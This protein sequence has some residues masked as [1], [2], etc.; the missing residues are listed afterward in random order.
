MMLSKHQYRFP[1]PQTADRPH[2]AVPPVLAQC[3][4]QVVIKKEQR[5]KKELQ[6]M[7][8]N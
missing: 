2:R 5:G 6:E 3:Q 7:K 1:N 8:S 4:G